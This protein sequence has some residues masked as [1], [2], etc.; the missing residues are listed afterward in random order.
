MYP[1]NEDLP[2]CEMDA[3]AYGVNVDSLE[4]SINK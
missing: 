3:V 1:S 4:D 2:E